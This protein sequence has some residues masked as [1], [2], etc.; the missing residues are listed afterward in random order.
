M[1]EAKRMLLDSI[2]CLLL[3]LEKGGEAEALEDIELCG[4]L[5]VELLFELALLGFKCQP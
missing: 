2:C 4:E 5:D 1:T 3:L